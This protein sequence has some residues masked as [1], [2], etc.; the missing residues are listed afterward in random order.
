MAEPVRIGFVGVGGIAR[1]HL[2]QLQATGQATIAALCDVREES[3]ASAAAE[4]GGTVYTDYRRMLDAETLDALYVCVPPSLHTGAEL[5]ACERGIHLFVEKPVALTMPQALEIQAAIAQAGV[6]AAAGYVMRNWPGI[7]AAQEYLA[8]KTV[9]LVSANRWHGIA[10]GD[11]HWWRRMDI[12]GGQLVEQATHN[13]DAVRWIAG[14]I[15][16]VWAR[17]EYASLAH[18]PNFSIPASQVVA[19]ELASGAAG[20]LTCSC[21]LNQGGG[22]GNWDF[23]LPDERVSIVGAEARR[24]PVAA[25]EDGTL[26]SSQPTLNIDEAFVQA[27]ASGDGSLIR[28]TYAD[29][30]RTLEV[31]LAANESAATGQVVECRAWRS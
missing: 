1:H 22:G 14:E 10:G 30:V 8:G 25:G 6:L 28:S 3:A 11:D 13:L 12:S 26:R 29:A 18:L 27:V 15:K 19:F 31:T 5:L 23:L 7:A 2:K 9:S 17:Y 16:A 24:A 21:V 20:T 4:Y